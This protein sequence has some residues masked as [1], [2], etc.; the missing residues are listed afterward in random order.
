MLHDA[1]LSQ[2]QTVVFQQQATAESLDVGDMK[3]SAVAW[4]G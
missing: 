1:R 2:L 3:I 4:S